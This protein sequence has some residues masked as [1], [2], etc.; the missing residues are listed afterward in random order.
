M[1]NTTVVGWISNNDEM[2]HRKIKNLVSGC[3]HHKLSRNVSKIA[4]DFK[5][6]S[7]IH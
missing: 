6:R 5:K 2:E 1:D 3:Q 7:G 4:I